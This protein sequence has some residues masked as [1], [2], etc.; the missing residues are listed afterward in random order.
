MTTKSSIIIDLEDPR[1][2]AIAEVLAN[3]SAKKILGVLAEKE[4]SVSEISDRLGMALNTV[5]YNVKKLVDSGLIEKTQRM[6]WSSKGKR[7]LLYKISNKRIVIS[8]RTLMRG[9]LPTVFITMLLAVGI[10]VFVGSGEQKI[11]EY[12]ASNEGVVSKLVGGGVERA[13]DSAASVAVPVAPPAS[14][15]VVGSVYS[16]LSNAPNSWVWFL[17][18]GLSA[19][20]IFLLWNWRRR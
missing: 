14:D 10:K 20:V 15:G 8:P 12:A 1:S 6:F 2:T 11:I 18:G 5:D 3:T 17:I 16:A 4:M 13:V 9:V 7:M 19:L